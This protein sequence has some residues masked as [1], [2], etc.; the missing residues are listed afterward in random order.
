V[1]CKQAP[2]CR[3]RWR[4][5]AGATKVLATQLATLSDAL[6]DPG[7]PP[8]IVGAGDAARPGGRRDRDRLDGAL[9]GEPA[10][11]VLI[12]QG[13]VSSS[14]DAV[15]QG[16]RRLVLRILARRRATKAKVSVPAAKPQRATSPDPAPR[17]IAAPND[18]K[19]LSGWRW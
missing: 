2:R 11:W 8:T 19:L 14:R 13:A 9:S 17:K 6:G 5:L 4:R 10:E 3:R 12:I 1:N 18:S 16:H 15:P 7:R